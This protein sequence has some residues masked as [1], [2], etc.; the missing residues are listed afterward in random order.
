MKD[1]K[2][3][4]LDRR[5]VVALSTSALAIT[6]G[7]R[8]AL[9]SA[10][11][12]N[13]SPSERLDT[14]TLATFGS[15]PTG[16]ACSSSALRMASAVANGRVIRIPAG[17]YRFAE[18]VAFSRET[19]LLAEGEVTFV[20][21]A[22]A[23]PTFTGAHIGA[24]VM[25]DISFVN[26]AADSLQP[27]I[28]FRSSG[29][30]SLTGCRFS[31]VR[32]EVVPVDFSDAQDPARP[33]SGWIDLS[34]SVFEGRGSGR[35]DD[36]LCVIA[37]AEGV[38]FR[39]VVFKGERVSEMLQTSY[40]TG[41]QVADRLKF[42]G[43]CLEEAWDCYSSA[44]PI[45]WRDGSWELTSGAVFSFKADGD[46][47]PDC[48][49]PRKTVIQ[50]CRGVTKSARPFYFGGARGLEFEDG[51]QEVHFLENQSLS[52]GEKGSSVYIVADFRG[53]H[54]VVAS[55]NSNLGFT[56]S[57]QEVQDAF[58]FVACGDIVVEGNAVANCALANLSSGNTQAGQRY[59]ASNLSAVFARNQ[60][61]GAHSLGVVR[62]TGAADHRQLQLKMEGNAATVRHDYSNTSTRPF[63]VDG[64]IPGGTLTFIDNDLKVLGRRGGTL[65]IG[66]S[67]Q[68]SYVSEGNVWDRA[69]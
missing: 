3:K 28:V 48:S 9:P 10:A 38:D 15:D 24:I 68:A 50:G 29:P 41:E 49:F 27:H 7:V 26:G 8:S 11:A 14:I 46:H 6:A 61:A 36:R 18:Q 53:L 55:N 19:R 37:G 43:S 17:R 12:T 52:D 34:G 2:V 66:L 47:G 58:N 4:R 59:R 16:M 33:P 44:G 42:I 30:I 45:M 32:L 64:P 23:P 57:F 22:A 51:F 35:P 13:G 54:K 65:P 39:D 20:L 21:A 62:V 56:G 63:Y 69:E 25:S 60:I 31:Q 5:Q 67:A 1:G 40:F